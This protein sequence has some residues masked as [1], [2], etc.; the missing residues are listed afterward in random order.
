MSHVV[1]AIEM[2]GRI[3]KYYPGIRVQ[4]TQRHEHGYWEVT[5]NVKVVCD[6]VHSSP[7]VYCS[8]AEDDQC[9]RVELRPGFEW[10][11]PKITSLI[12][13]L[14]AVVAKGMATAFK[15]ESVEIVS[16]EEWLEKIPKHPSV[17]RITLKPS[18]N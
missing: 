6:A 18:D 5:P 16:Y 15:W 13:E 2:D 3:R 7:A 12:E 8:W 4:L 17:K 9:L 14:D 1:I 10:D 11:E